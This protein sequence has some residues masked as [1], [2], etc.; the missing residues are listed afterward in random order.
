MC[1][2]CACCIEIFIFEAILAQ[3]HHLQ[4][5]L[6]AYVSIHHSVDIKKPELP[7]LVDQSRELARRLGRMTVCSYEKRSLLALAIVQ[8]HVYTVP[9]RSPLAPPK[10]QQ[11]YCLSL[12]PWRATRDLSHKRKA[13]SI[14]CIQALVHCHAYT[15]SMQHSWL[16]AEARY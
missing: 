3:F 11:T 7:R 9:E 15:P 5:C 12:P 10:I 1:Q 16:R 14:V 6:Y 4:P 2:E 8:K 13:P